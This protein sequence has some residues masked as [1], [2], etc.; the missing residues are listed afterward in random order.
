VIE[1]GSALTVHGS[2]KG[3][4][5]SGTPFANE[6]IFIVHFAAAPLTTGSLPKIK[7]LKEFVD[8]AAVMR[9]FAEDRAANE[10]LE[11]AN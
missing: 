8:S 9:F 11:S 10:M 1:A 5:V 4:S 6:Y 3:K 2:T 7:S